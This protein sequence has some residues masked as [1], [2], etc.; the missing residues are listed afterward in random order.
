MTDVFGNFSARI[1]KGSPYSWL[2]LPFVASTLAARLVFRDLSPRF[3]PQCRSAPSCSL[4]Y[5]VPY[6]FIDYCCLNSQDAPSC[7]VNHCSA[8]FLWM[9][10]MLFRILPLAC[11]SILAGAVPLVSS[12]QTGT[13]ISLTKRSRLSENGV[14]NR[15]ALRAHVLKATAYAFS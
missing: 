2:P 9:R 8:S 15:E 13:A 1:P 11:L 5:D 3:R 4:A 12:S 14:V 10:M 6:T 7:E